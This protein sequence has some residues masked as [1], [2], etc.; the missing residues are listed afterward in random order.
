MQLRTSCL[1]HCFFFPF[2]VRRGRSTHLGFCFGS[3][4]FY[5][6]ERLG[7]ASRKVKHYL[8]TYDSPEYCLCQR[9]AFIHNPVGKVVFTSGDLD[10][11]YVVRTSKIN[12]SNYVTYLDFQIIFSVDQYRANRFSLPLSLN[13]AR[14]RLNLL[15]LPGSELTRT[16]S[17]FDPSVS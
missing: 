6:L 5:D 2:C 11:H 3:N 8:V 17:F 12:V 15:S 16:L 4:Y 1:G 10:S 14:N 7:C 13:S 9:A